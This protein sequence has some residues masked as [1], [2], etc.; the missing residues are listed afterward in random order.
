VH[1][2]A[3][4]KT[5]LRVASFIF[6][7]KAGIPFKEIE[8]VL[9]GSSDTA[10]HLEP[11]VRSQKFWRPEVAFKCRRAENGAVVTT[12]NSK[13]VSGAGWVDYLDL[14]SESRSKAR[15]CPRYIEEMEVDLIKPGFEAGGWAMR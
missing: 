13:K 1:I 2:E 10:A 3:D 5:A 12:D 14:N 15:T 4:R 7:L 6:R 9:E 11:Y 8:I